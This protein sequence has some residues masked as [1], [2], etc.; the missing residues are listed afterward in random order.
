VG[1]DKGTVLVLITLVVLPIAA[2]AFARSGAAWQRVGKG[3]FAIEQ[4]PPPRPSEPVRVDRAVQAAEARQMLEA[5]AYRRS[6]SGGEP[7]DVEAEVSRL[8]EAPAAPA[9]EVDEELREEVRR[10]VVARNERRMRRGEAP[11]DVEA[12][13]ARQLDEIS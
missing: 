5:K 7:I 11:L 9:A 6:R 4:E 10:L 3:E 12:E 8:L 13:T 1:V 2:V